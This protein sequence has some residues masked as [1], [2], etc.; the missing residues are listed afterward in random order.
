MS[1]GSIE[2]QA[3][4]ELSLGEFLHAAVNRNPDKV[5]LQIV[6]Q[7]I[8]YGE[9]YSR[10]RQ[11]AAMFANLGVQR[12]DR[13]CLFLPNVPEFHYCW[14]GLSLLGA[15]SVPVNVAYKRD[16]A[17]YIFDNAGATAV[18]THRSLV[19]VAEAASAISPTVKHKL[20]ATTELES[21]ASQPPG[22]PPATGWLNLG[23]LLAASEE[24]TH[25]PE[26]STHEISMLVYTSG[27]TGNPR[28]VQVTHL[29]YVAAGQGFAHWTEAS[30]A[31]RFFT[32]LPFFHANAQYYSTMGSLAAGATLVV[33][34]R[35][36]ASRF[37]DQ[38]REANATVVNF[39]G[40]MMPVLA[41]QPESELDRQ[42]NVRLFYGSPAFSPDFL[43]AFKERFD[44]EIIVG[45]GMTETCY[46]SIEKIGQQRRP[47]SSGQPRLH[48]DSGFVNRIRIV[49][50]DG[51]P[52]P[53]GQPGEITIS[54]PAVMPG[55][56]RNQEQTDLALREG[57]LHTGD[58]GWA[59]EE[60]F[61]YFVDRKK[62]VIRRRGENISSQEVEDAIKRHP[63]V[64]DCAVIA[65]PSELGED[66]VKAYVT[67]RP[68][69]TVDP[70][71]IVR[72]CA[73][74]L[75]YF[76]VPRY[77]EVREEMPRT[78]SLRVRKDLLR[79]E[80]E[81]LIEGCFDREAAGIRIR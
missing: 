10:V 11:A 77:I 35:F 19:D 15:I 38:V 12:G 6:G 80:R 22:E 8:T 37:W 72:W 7:Q 42:N 25:L 58:L 79:Q 62:D 57:W 27:T 31:D 3:T 54:N 26:V 13:V 50:D 55:Y 20:L 24:L 18:V 16:E 48:P 45:F 71:T 56:W 2:K 70:E 63:T 68:P 9:F 64:L 17:A 75:A 41:K 5:F 29:M 21:E 73:E 34:E 49:D 65:V 28:G 60:G 66:E 59:D 53:S 52:V 61:L 14:F 51:R 43:E 4:W 81:D 74:N 32:C 69:A 46:G 44:T 76:K 39:I 1:T 40:M 36:S 47:N 30:E 78:P 33:A 67:P 23:E